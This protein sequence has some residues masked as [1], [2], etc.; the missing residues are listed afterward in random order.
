MLHYVEAELLLEITG[1]E[2]LS[3]NFASSMSEVLSI[4]LDAEVNKIRNLNFSKNL[5]ILRLLLLKLMGNSTKRSTRY[6]YWR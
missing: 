6:R 1:P 5:D 2:F 3:P 4:V